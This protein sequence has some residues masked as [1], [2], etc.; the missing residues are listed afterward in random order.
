MS[1][2]SNEKE[3]IRAEISRKRRYLTNS[4][5]KDIDKKINNK[6]EK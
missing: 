6:I 4:E 2:K 1:K 5:K 3:K